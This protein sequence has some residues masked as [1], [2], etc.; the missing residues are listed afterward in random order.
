MLRPFKTFSRRL[1]RKRGLIWLASISII[2][3]F[4]G[5]LG[6]IFWFVRIKVP[7][8]VR[9]E[10]EGPT[11]R[12]VIPHRSFQLVK[13]GDEVAFSLE[14]PFPPTGSVTSVKA[15]PGGL[16]LTITPPPPSRGGGGEGEISGTITLRSRRL[17]TAF[18]R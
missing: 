5:S 8:A 18:F 2:L 9:L 14:R 4:S 13:V 11:I 12:A 16:E 15:A 7:Y 1:F 10:V 17:I 3:V 6:S